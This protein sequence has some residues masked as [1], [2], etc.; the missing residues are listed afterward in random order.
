[1]HIDVCSTSMLLYLSVF[2]KP[3]ISI[4]C[5][6]EYLF[7]FDNTFEIHDDIEVLKRMGMA[8]G[9]EKGT[10]SSSDL[11]KAVR[12]VPKSLEPYVLGEHISSRK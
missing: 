10:C 7:N 8:H 3:L 6:Y 5:R 4:P 12:M 2:S 1:M 9:L 11:Q